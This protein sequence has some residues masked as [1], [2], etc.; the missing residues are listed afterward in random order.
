MQTKSIEQLQQD[1]LAFGIQVAREGNLQ[2]LSQFYNIIGT[3]AEALR[4]HPD[5]NNYLTCLE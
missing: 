2:L 3:S 5:F 1:I 4:E